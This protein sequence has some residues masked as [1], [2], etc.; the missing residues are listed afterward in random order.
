MFGIDQCDVVDD[1]VIE[2]PVVS[3]ETLA[4]VLGISKQTLYKHARAG[5]L[6]KIGPNRFAFKKSVQSYCT[7]LQSRI[8][9]QENMKG[10]SATMTARAKKENAQAELAQLKAE[11]VRSELVP[12]AE[13]K[14]AWTGI[15][16]RI[17]AACTALH[18]TLVA[19]AGLTEAQAKVV[20]T[21]IREVL[22]ELG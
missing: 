17:R 19:C 5:R 13:V 15:A 8:A 14:E 21:A 4:A 7:Y 12:V 1:D 11:R 9:S 3:A 6:K 20:R 22:A 18:P 16:K 10:M 2:G